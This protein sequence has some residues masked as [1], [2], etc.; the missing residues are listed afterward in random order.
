[1][2]NAQSALISS[3]LQWWSDAG[4]IDAV[5]DD[6]YDWFSA[7]AAISR[8]PLPGQPA[9]SGQAAL[10]DA[11]TIM[12]TSHTARQDTAEPPLAVAPR[13]AAPHVAA[14]ATALPRVAVPMPNELVAFEEWLASTPD[15]P[16]AHWSPIR[17]MPQGPAG[18]SLMILA[19]APDVADIESGQLAS[20]PAGRLLD[21]MLAAIGL[22]RDAV[23]LGSL[24]LTRPVG[25][26][27]DGEAATQL[28]RIAAHH[29]RLARPQHILL[30]GQQTCQLMTGENVPPDDHGQREINLDGGKRAV[31]AIHHPRLLLE[32]PLLKRSAWTVLKRLKE[33][34]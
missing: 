32:R 4:L 15:L 19:D 14:S 1:M 2:I 23:R 28:A 21:A 25:G 18:A 22:K 16:G 20:G 13:S 6:A 3:Y 24:A 26:R 11:G 33:L 9:P 12:P 17:L 30:L 29:V 34:N 7:P 5:A 31:S 10:S 8:P 27:L